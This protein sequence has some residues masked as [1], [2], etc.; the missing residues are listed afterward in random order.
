[1]RCYVLVRSYH[2]LN[3]YIYADGLTRFATEKYDLT[4]LKNSY[5]H[6]TNT[7]INQL[8]PTLNDE[9]DEVGPGCKWN[10]T[11]LRDYFNYSKGISFDKVWNQIKA[12]VLLT[13][14]P[15]TSQIAPTPNGCFELYG[16]GNE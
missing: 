2:P 10:F 14:L 7:S 6:L 9:K 12:Q 1:M 16:F 13:I 11:K 15:I 4:K 5:S 8:S 3:I